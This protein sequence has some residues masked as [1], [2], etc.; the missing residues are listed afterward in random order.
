MAREGYT[1]PGKLNND[2]VLKAIN[3]NGMFPVVGMNKGKPAPDK[4]RTTCWCEEGTQ[5]VNGD[6]FIP[7]IP[8][9]R[10]KALEVSEEEIQKFMDVL[11]SV[12]W[13][14]RE[15]EDNEFPVVEEP[16]TI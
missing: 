16:E 6:W 14:I 8:D 1:G 9:K 15:V 2:K 10:L 11:T 3:N 7:R 5:L 4:C 12:G 13:T